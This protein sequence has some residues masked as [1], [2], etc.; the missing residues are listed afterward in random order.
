MKPFTR[1]LYDVESNGLLPEHVDP[2]FCMDRIHSMGIKCLDT[3]HKRS[4]VNDDLLPLSD[5]DREAL[6]ALGHTNIGPLSE[7]IRILEEAEYVTG[8]NIIDFDENALKIPFPKY[9][10]KGNLVD[11]L[12]MSRMVFADIKDTDFRMVA[13]GT[14]QGKYIGMHGLEAWGQRLGLA[15]GDYKHEREDALKAHH[16]DAGQEPPTDEELHHYVWG[17]WNV[18]MHDYM[19]LDIDVNFLLWEKIQEFTWSRESVILEHSIHALM[20][21][22]E[23]NGFLFDIEGAEKLTDI[24][25]VQYDDFT[26]IA[27]EQIGVWYRPAKT[28]R[29]VFLAENGENSSRRTW[30]EVSEAKRSIK[31]AASNAKVVASG[32]YSS[33]RADR[34]EGAPFVVIE[35]KEF[36]PNSRQQITERLQTLYGWEPQDFTE[37][38]QAKVDDEILRNL[39]ET[40]P[41][42]ETLAELFFLKK[43]LGMLAD[44]K[45]GWL[46]LVRKDGRIHGRVNVGGAVT[47]RATHSAPNISQVPGVTAVE[48]KDEAKGQAFLDS[49]PEFTDTGR[50][51]LV[52]AKWNDK[53]GEWKIL[54]RGRSG[55]YGWDSRELFI[56]PKGYTLVGCDLSG[57]EFRC[58]GHLTF[59]F[60]NGEIVDVVLNGD[61]H[62]QN[63]DLTGIS[64]SL[65]K[66]LL[67]ACVDM[68]TMAL[69]KDGWKY[70]HEL[71]V[72][73]LALTYNMEK[74]IQEWKPIQ[75]LHYVED[76]ERVRIEGRGLDVVCTPD[77][78]WPTFH[79]HMVEGEYVK[80][81]K[82]CR[83]DELTGMHTVIANAPFVGDNQVWG[84]SEAFTSP[85]YGTD[86]TKVVMNM[87]T[88]ER[89]AFL[90][91]FLIADGHQNKRKPENWGFTQNPGEHFDAALAA[92]YLQSET[93]LTTHTSTTTLKTEIC[94][95]RTWGCQKLELVPLERGPVWCMTTENS[96]FVMRRGNFVTITGNCLYGGGDAKL[97]SIIEPF[98]SE[99]RQKTLGGQARIKLM[100]AM[101]SLKAAMK[102][103]KREA[104][105][106]RGTIAGL[107][108][109]RLY[110]RS[111]HAALNLRLQSDGALIAKKW[112]LIIDDLFYEEGWDHGNGLDYS[113][114]S[115]SH[116]ETQIAVRDDLAPR[117]A[118]LMIEAARLAGEH[119]KLNVPVAAEAKLGHTWATT[120]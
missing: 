59:P 72:G 26:E 8:H 64:R 9:T 35:L 93:R 81:R 116:D 70:Y 78:R 100:N 45:N 112:L 80:T 77:H 60:D 88:E 51:T 83:T 82:Y 90:L 54:T 56:V 7:G 18:A 89:K 48:F 95:S 15:K 119:F 92:L 31:F 25:R 91:G 118:E 94:D 84:P 49:L 101:P 69:T 61:I 98:A 79:R 96:S 36:N 20:V 102:A 29:D 40:V 41:I 14:L 63:A 105:M 28:V 57:I 38:G 50:K 19:M 2:P 109:R 85:K 115:W 73:D 3:G 27:V 111:D 110:V 17:T 99:P 24:L 23:R 44:G 53:K 55:G 46:K 52:K 62:Q 6:A 104:R 42:A 74:D 37:K 106:N 10:R 1:C 21:Q 30:G 39:S 65:A 5:E 12:V 11:T 43:R 107:D 33:L 117:A 34:V 86:W 114:C 47:G 97:G 58:L 4:F 120:H 75:H 66:R 32:D 16:K 76:A 113:M 103:I 13:K 67:Y 22:Q 71:K 68:E 108:G 87:T